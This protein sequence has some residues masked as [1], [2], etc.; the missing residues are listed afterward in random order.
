MSEIST[1]SAA[2]WPGVGGDVAVNGGAAELLLAFKDE[3]YIDR[4]RADRLEQ[5]LDGFHMNEGLSFVVRGAAGIEILTPH[6]RLEG[7]RGP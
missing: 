6:R 4:Q 3:L 5:R 2:S 7:R 1:T